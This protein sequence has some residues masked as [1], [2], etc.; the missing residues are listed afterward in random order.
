MKGKEFTQM[1]VC[2]EHSGLV[3]AIQNI[4]TSIK[5]IEDKQDCFNKK[6]DI[7]VEQQVNTDKE[8]ATEKIENKWRQK[9]I[10]C[11]WGVIG[12]IVGSG[13]TLIASLMLERYIERQ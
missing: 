2:P 4:A 8:I 5:R 1:N 10:A 6:L 9:A 12:G 7:I 11:V 3:V 13:G